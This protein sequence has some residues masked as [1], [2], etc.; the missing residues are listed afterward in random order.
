[1]KKIL[2]LFLSALLLLGGCSIR[3]IPAP[4]PTPE[5]S[6]T[7]A[8]A[9]TPAPTPTPCP[10]LS[11]S[12]G[13]C[14]DCGELCSHEQWEEGACVRCGLHCSH[15]AHNSE[16]GLCS[17]CLE[18]CRHTYFNGICSRCGQAP[19]FSELDIPE[20]LR[21]KCAQQGSVEHVIYETQE[22][23]GVLPG[24]ELKYNKRMSVY[25]PYGYNPDEQYDVIVI[26]HGM[27][28]LETYWLDEE[29]IYDKEG[30]TIFTRDVLD[31]M[32]QQGLIPP[33][34]VCSPTFYRDKVVN[35]GYTNPSLFATEM[36]NDIIPFIVENYS[37]YASEP[38]LSAVSQA[39]EHFAF[40]G[41][42]MGS[43]IGFQS[44]LSLSL[45]IFGYYGLFS[46]CGTYPA[47]ILENINKDEF[48]D[49]PI[50]YLFNAV[51]E[52]DIARNEHCYYFDELVSKTDRLEMEKNASM[53]V[54]KDYAHEFRT[55]IVG[56]YDCLQVFFPYTDGIP[57]E[58]EGA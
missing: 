17:V 19:V 12:E 34:I 25:L 3:Q 16:N 51:G 24:V 35:L 13:M 43:M 56:L 23:F 36:R 20:D 26:L 38:T 7:L 30:G 2:A 44:A 48:K 22:Y 8:P 1:M 29:Q 47:N 49:L 41:L 54:V 27:N 53:V 14:Q 32:I 55:W 31:N 57:P 50:Y 18:F 6:P 5:P 9:P 28:C 46:G 40:V 4:T 11:W 10:H 42:S 45:D 39:R 58:K 37:T 33:V 52:W 15:L 21:G